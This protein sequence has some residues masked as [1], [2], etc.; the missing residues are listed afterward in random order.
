[1]KFYDSL[2]FGERISLQETSVDNYIKVH[3]IIY[4]LKK[5]GM[6]KIIKK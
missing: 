2:L 3:K 5:Q 1:M 4:L 6:E